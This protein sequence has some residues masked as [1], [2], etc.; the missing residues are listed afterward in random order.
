AEGL[1]GGI[2]ANWT[3]LGRTSVSGLR[4]TFLQREGRLTLKDDAWHLLVEPHAFDMLLDRLPWSIATLR[5]AWM[6]RVLH[7]EWR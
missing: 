4:E 1:L 5:L 6:D 7:V 3:A 2:V